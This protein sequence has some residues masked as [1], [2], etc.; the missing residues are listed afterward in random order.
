MFKILIQIRLIFY[1]IDYIV[2]GNIL[3]IIKTNR[4]YYCCCHHSNDGDNNG[5]DNKGGVRIRIRSSLNKKTNY[6]MCTK[7]NCLN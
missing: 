4:H 7:L 2:P 1:N 6:L 5:D 3:I